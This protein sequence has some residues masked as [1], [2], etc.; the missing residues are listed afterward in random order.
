MITMKLYEKHQARIYTDK[1]E[2][3]KKIKEIIKGIDPFEAEYLPK[4][5]IA[6]FGGEVEYIYNGKFY[7]IDM[8]DVM[9]ECWKAGIYAFYC[10]EERRHT[11]Y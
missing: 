4:D 10:I 2:N 5:L 9:R 6:V 7:D 11:I 8:D 1:A 3:I